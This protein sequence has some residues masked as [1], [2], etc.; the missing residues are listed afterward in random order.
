MN[1]DLTSLLNIISKINEK[2]EE[3]YKISG[4]K[5]NYKRVA[6]AEEAGS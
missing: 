6:G 5:F 4:E 3:I 2:Y 1:E